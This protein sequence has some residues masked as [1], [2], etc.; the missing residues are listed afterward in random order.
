MTCKVAFHFCARIA[1]RGPYRLW[2][3]IGCSVAVVSSCVIRCIWVLAIGPRSYRPIQCAFTSSNQSALWSVFVIVSQLDRGQGTDKIC[4]LLRGFVGPLR[5]GK[6]STYQKVDQFFRNFCGWTEPIHWVLDRNFGR[7]DRAHYIEV[8]FIYFWGQKIV[9]Y[10]EDFVIWRF[11]ISRFHKYEY[12]LSSFR[13]S[14]DDLWKWKRFGTFSP[15][16]L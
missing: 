10:I 13:L 15:L 9:C 5:P 2:T 3:Q 14:V 8:L 7:M 11:I 6:R 16:G 1:A 4:S 12:E